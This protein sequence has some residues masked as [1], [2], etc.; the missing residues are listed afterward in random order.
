MNTKL[1]I[2]FLFIACLSLL[3]IHSFSQTT[4]TDSLPGDPS[5]AV[6]PVQDLKFGAF[7]QSVSGGTITIASDGTRSTTGSVVQMGLGILFCQA[8]FDVEAPVGTVLSIMNGPDVTLT[9]SN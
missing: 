9:G 5:I 3:S 2:Q 7:Y 1:K 6:F 8:I 4:P